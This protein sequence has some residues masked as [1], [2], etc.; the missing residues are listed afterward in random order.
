MPNKM[1]RESIYETSC[2]SFALGGFRYIKLQS[3]FPARQ[4]REAGGRSGH[5]RARIGGQGQRLD[6]GGGWH[7]AGPGHSAQACC[8]DALR[9]SDSNDYR[10]PPFLERRD[11]GA[12]DYAADAVCQEPRLDGW[13]A[14]GDAG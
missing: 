13:V 14:L 9:F 4:P 10:R 7:N 11:R 12:A 2:V 6:D 8:C 5:S 3:L 1:K